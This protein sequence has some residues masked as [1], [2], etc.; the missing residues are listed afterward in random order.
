VLSPPDAPALRNEEPG[1]GLRA[2]TTAPGRETCTAA[3]RKDTGAATQE[4]S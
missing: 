3:A 1:A 2:S 4:G